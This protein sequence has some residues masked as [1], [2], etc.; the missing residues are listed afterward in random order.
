MKKHSIRM[1]KL[2][3]PQSLN[4]LSMAQEETEG[5]IKRMA[6]LLAVVTI[7][8]GSP[9]YVDRLANALSKE[10]VSRVVY[11][12]LRVLRVGIYNGEVT[13]GTIKV[14]TKE[15]EAEY[16]AITVKVKEKEGQEKHYNVI[17]YLPTDTDVEKFMSLV[18]KDIYYSRKAGALAMSIANKVLL[19]E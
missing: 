16:P 4:I 13:T 18:E 1:K 3:N 10:A 6:N 17:G 9:T 11:E 19:G 2:I 7:Y 5:V 14:K 8:S 12:A 15:G